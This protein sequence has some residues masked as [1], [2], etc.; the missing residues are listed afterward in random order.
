MACL[1][2]V[3]LCLAATPWLKQQKVA[4]LQTTTDYPPDV[5]AQKGREMAAAFGYTQRPADTALWLNQ[6]LDVLTYLNLLPQ[7][8]RWTEWLNSESVVSA[9]YRESPEPMVAAPDGGVAAANPPV[10]QPGMT[11]FE[12][13]AQGRLRGFLG[14]PTRGRTATPVGVDAVFQAAQLDAGKFGEVTP[15]T[16]P[17]VPT[18]RLQ[19]WEGPHPTIPWM[20]LHIETGWWQGRVTY[21][22]FRWP[23]TKDTGPTRYNAW[24]SE[25]QEVLLPVLTGI[26]LTFALLFARRNWRQGRGDRRGAFVVGMAMFTLNL[27]NWAAS[28]HAVP[29]T[30]MTRMLFEAL[31]AL[32]YHVEPRTG[33]EVE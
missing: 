32:D 4:F 9:T 19:A 33:G 16:V 22:N 7:P 27:L 2:A 5:L 23:W 6:R 1:A 12:L 11:E 10:T 18:D 8:R 31:A 28:V 20:R 30:A 13:D 25:I 21:V 14:V 15:A 17:P 29:S 24:I 3:L 26:V